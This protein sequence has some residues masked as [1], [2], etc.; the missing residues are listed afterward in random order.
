MLTIHDVDS[1]TTITDLKTKIKQAI[2]DNINNKKIQFLQLEAQFKDILA[3]QV[4]P[5]DCIINYDIHLTTSDGHE[6]N[7]FIE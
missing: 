6:V 5:F 7:E 4:L 3:L 2:E 1:K